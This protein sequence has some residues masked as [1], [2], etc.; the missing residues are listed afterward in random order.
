[1]EAVVARINLGFEI[2]FTIV[3]VF[4]L[5]AARRRSPVAARQ[6]RSAAVACFIGAV[7]MLAL[8]WVSRW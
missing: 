4:C 3:G 1:M 8:G 6:L 7:V 2:V 5:I